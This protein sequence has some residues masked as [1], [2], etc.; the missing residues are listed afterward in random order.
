MESDKRKLTT[1]EIMKVFAGIVLTL[2]ALYGVYSYIDW[3]IERKINNPEFIRKISSNIRPSV[4]FDSRQSIEIDL[5]A[6]QFIEKIEVIPSKDPRF[7]KKIV[8]SPKE[9]LAHA[10]FLTTLD[11]TEFAIMVERGQKFDWVY[12]LAISEYLG[13][14][15]KTRF[16]L[17][18]VK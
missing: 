5:G 14:I 3:R 17:E 12:H 16:R 8:V 6:M 9:Y 13:N 7:P 4:V 18:I 15:K 1:L 11:E 2:A 10:P